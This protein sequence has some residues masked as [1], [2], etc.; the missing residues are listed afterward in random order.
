MSKREQKAA[1]YTNGENGMEPLTWGRIKVAQR[2]GLEETPDNDMP[3][4]AAALYLMPF[5]KLRALTPANFAESCT[6]FARDLPFTRVVECGQALARDMEAIGASQVEAVGKDREGSERA[7]PSPAT[8][9]P[10]PPSGSE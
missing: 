2:C 6:V 9:Q 4:A 7:E 5:E 8:T 10:S 1:A 3:D